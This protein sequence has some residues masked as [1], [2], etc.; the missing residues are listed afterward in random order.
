VKPRRIAQWASGLAALLALSMAAAQPAPTA[1]N[2]ILLI[3]TGLGPATTTAARLMRYP[4]DGSLAM[5]GMPA[6]AR[7]RTWSLD[8]QTSDSAA[9]VSAMLSGVKVR[10]D[11]VAMDS[12]TRSIGFAPGKDQIRNIPN[13]ENRCPVSG[14]GAPSRTLLELAIARNRS[15][16]IVTTGRLTGG[17]AAATYAH[18]CHRD[19]E[20][21]VA[22]QAVPGGAGFNRFLGRG[23]DVMMGGVSATWRPFDAGRR[24]RGRPDARELIGEMQALGYT[25]ISDLTAMNA[26]PVGAGSRMIGVFDFAE[27]GM[28]YDVDRDPKREPSLAE[29]TSKAIEILS[30]NRNGYFLVVEAGRIDQALRAANPRRALVDAIAFDDAVKVALDRSER[31]NTL[32][33]VTGDHDTTMALIGG[34]RRG[35]DVLGLHLNP[36]S[37]RPDVDANGSTFTS[38]VFGTGPNRPDRRVSLD[39][40]TVVEK[41]YVSESAI[42]LPAGTGG[43][44]DV[45][46]RASGAGAGA[47]HGTIDNT[48][49]FGLIRK[50]ADL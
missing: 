10:N 45:I 44:G 34:G 2:V 42:R 5:D 19:A 33:V 24:P 30:T 16:G 6:V 37:G 47:F 1:Q 27:D 7:V 43:G 50:A 35:S 22:R 38:I 23:V 31:S 36:V 15:T 18:V 41:D 21:E 11:V 17:A 4:E 40:P 12:T 20:F 8:A 13:G 26:A 3:G 9:A 14:N 29:M 46:L 49:V 48:Q 28:S 32:V 25:F 39:T